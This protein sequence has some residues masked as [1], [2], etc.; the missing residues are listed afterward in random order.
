M[1]LSPGGDSFGEVP[2]RPTGFVQQVPV[3]RNNEGDT[4][5]S[6]SEE[7]WMDLSPGGGSFGEVPT[8]PNSICVNI[9]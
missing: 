5:D 8:R 3:G 1:E 9:L 6:K 7:V 2:T 4:L